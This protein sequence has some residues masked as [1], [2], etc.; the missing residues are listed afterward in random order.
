MF[1]NKN[2]GKMFYFRSQTPAD[3]ATIF[4]VF[5]YS[6]L[7][8][9]KR[10]IKTSYWK[11]YILSL[12]EIPEDE[13]LAEKEESEISD[14]DGDEKELDLE[15]EEA[16]EEKELEAEEKE[17]VE[18]EKDLEEE[19]KEDEIDEK[20]LN[21]ENKEDEIDEKELEEEIK[22]DEIAEKDFEEENK[23]DEI[24]EKDSDSS[25]DEVYKNE[26]GII[27]PDVD[28][29]EEIPDEEFFHKGVMDSEAGGPH[30]GFD[31]EGNEKHGFVRRYFRKIKDFFKGLGK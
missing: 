13:L 29:K 18:L 3:F 21:E 15:D 30:G 10:K 9:M 20:D 7:S 16:D 17:L 8:F 24:A 5:S 11:I 12:E 31:E 14:D 26:G 2:G 25:D 4:S 23:E 1:A 28:D 6:I 22:E 27:F 19:N